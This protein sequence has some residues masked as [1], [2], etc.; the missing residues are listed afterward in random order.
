MM[1]IDWSFDQ[2]MKLPTSSRADRATIP[3][4]TQAGNFAIASE[5]PIGVLPSSFMHTLGLA[6][7]QTYFCP[8]VEAVV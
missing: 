3:S 1:M 5:F 8:Q 4:E 6:V 7:S 2:S